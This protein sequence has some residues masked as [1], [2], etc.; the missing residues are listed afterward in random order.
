MNNQLLSLIHI[1][2]NTNNFEWDTTLWCQGK[3]P[4]AIYTLCS[5]F[6]YGLVEGENPQDPQYIQAQENNLKYA[7]NMAAAQDIV[8]NLKQQ[9]QNITDDDLLNAFNFYMENDAFIDIKLDI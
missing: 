3:K 7:L 5:V 8:S 2:K 6:R 9:K 4:F 1:L